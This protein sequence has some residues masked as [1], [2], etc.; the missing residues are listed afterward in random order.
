MTRL[1]DDPAAFSDDML[2]GFVDAH[3]SY[4]RKVVGGVVR[5]SPAPAGK[6]VV[7]IGG[8]AG[9]YPAF[10]GIVGTGLADGAVVG[11]VFTS[12]SAGQVESVARS[13]SAGGGVLLMS[14]N[15]TGDVINFELA[16][17]ALCDT[18]IETTYVTVTDDVASAPPE[19]EAR[20]RGVAGGFV[21]FKVAGAA[22]DRG[23]PLAEVVRLARHA[24]SQTRTIGVAFAGCTLP[25]DSTP[26]FTVPPGRMSVGLGIHGEAGIAEEP[27]P[28]AA[29]LGGLLVDRLVGAAPAA[30]TDRVAVVLNGLGSVK[31]E[32]LF[33]VWATV[34]ARLR[35]LGLEV[36]EPEIGELV[37]SL[38]M[39]G[40]SLSLTWLDDELEPLWRAAA[41]TP[42]FRR[43]ARS[44]SETGRPEAE[45][46]E[47]TAPVVAPV[48]VVEH[49]DRCAA[50]V[51]EALDRVANR[52]EELG[53]ELGRLDAVAGDG[54]H[55]RGMIKGS[56][57]AL[58][59]ARSRAHRGG[60]VGATLVAAGDAWATSAGGT[61]G[62]L[63]GA[64]LTAAGHS[65]TDEIA[66]SPKSWADAVRAA[67]DE[68]CRL[69]KAAPGD[70]TMLDSFGPLVDA[71]DA[72][73]ASGNRWPEVWSAA[74]H[75]AQDAAQATA[76]LRPRVGRARPLAE[77]SVGTPDPGA[78]S[79][80]ACARA[81]MPP[82][83]T[84]GSPA[85][86]AQ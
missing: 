9:H 83:E 42:A 82:V 77:R 63:W 2:T 27:V 3:R 35:N 8:G 68:V 62:V 81:A 50:A 59:A 41:D 70:K 7:V 21:V 14:G 16:R 37:T 43:G 22:A 73:L 4:V 1:Y 15:Y 74:A 48:R 86:G 58:A 11:N 45:R 6:A 5:S 33:V 40:C 29:E 46:T 79:L 12:P 71:L 20:R 18:G 34:A 30:A 36:V 60:L 66:P 54:D 13:A 38:D 39:A 69:G 61:S 67:Y 44:P 19:E 56:I 17:D 85:G 31:Y 52:L 24:N 53:P 26:L 65:L 25:G 47:S 10:C 23:D 49:V 51:V 55:G 84:F 64:G 28:T 80:A 57:A 75:V 78:V 72:E 76:A 32:E